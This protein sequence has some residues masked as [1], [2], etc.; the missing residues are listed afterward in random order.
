MDSADLAFAGIARQ[1]E[2]IRAGEISSRELVELYLARIQKLDPQLNAFRIVLAEQAL[3]EADRAQERLDAGEEAPLLGVPVAVK[4]NVDLAGEPTT[5]GTGAY[6][7]AANQD[8][9]VI[10]RL[11]AAGAIVIGKTLT[12]ELCMWAF[13]ESATWG[14]TRNPWNLDYT[15]SGSSG[16]SAAAVSAGLVGA[17]LG[18]DGA[19]SIRRPSAR[20]GLFGLKPQRGRVPTEPTDGH[21]HGLTVFGPMTRT[22]LDAAVFLDAVVIAAP[23]AGSNRSPQ[24]G[25]YQ[26]ATL[27]SPGKL[28]IAISTKTPAPPSVDDEILQAIDAMSDLLRDLG[29]DVQNSDPDY[30]FLLP[31]FLPRYLRGVYD[32]AKAM[33]HWNRLERRTRTMAHLG[34]F[35]PRGVVSW[36]KS[37]EPSVVSRLNQVFNNCDVLMTPVCAR[38]PDKVGRWEGRGAISSLLGASRTITFTTPWNITGQPA[39]SVPAGFSSKG[40]PL[41]VQIVG[42]PN[43]E[44]TLLSLSAQIEAERPWA[45]WRPKMATADINYPL[46]HTP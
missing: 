42:Q 19:G 3:A 15:P 23:S 40:L 20:C 32:D 44:A 1:A 34:G 11:R 26:R 43:D 30:G 31:A 16:G 24:A 5:H 21:W 13:T 9:E 10:E 39:V 17:A 8:S 6:G 18:S 46:S 4:D 22:V 14:V 36:A 25:E 38:L 2:L 12:P 35:F 45:G 7:A 29:H 28:R 37:A 27:K 41:A 33:A